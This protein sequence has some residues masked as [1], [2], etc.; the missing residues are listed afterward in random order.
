[1]IPEALFPSF[2]QTLLRGGYNLLLGSGICLDSFNGK[3][4]N[5]RSADQLRRDLCTLTGARESTSLSRVYPLLNDAQRQ[6]E[7][8]EGFSQCTPGPSIKDLSRFLWRRVFTFNIDDVLENLYS[9]EETAKQSLIPL[10]FDSPFE[11]TPER[12][13]L[14]AIHLHGWVRHPESGFVFSATEY[15]RVMQNLNPWMHLLGE[16]L[17]TEPFIIAGTSLTEVDLEYYLSRRSP[18]TPRRDRGPSLLIE[19]D[20]DVVTKS[21]CERHQLLLIQATFGQFLDWL[22]QTFPSPPSVADLLVPDISTLFSEGL[23]NLQLVRFFSD[24]ELVTAGDEDLSPRPSPFLYGREPDWNDLHQHVDIE[25][26]DNTSLLTLVE[27]QFAVQEEPPANLIVALDDAGTGKTTT[28]KRV[29]HSVA[30]AGKPVLTVRTLSRIDTTNAA[31]CLAHAKNPLLLVVDG[32]ADHAEQLAGLLTFTQASTPI[33]VLACERMYRKEY[34]DIVFGAGQYQYFEMS[35]LIRP[36]LIQL[37][38][39]YRQYGLIG[40]PRAL[41]NPNDFAMKL[42]SDPVAVAVCRILNDFRPLEAIVDSLWQAAAPEDRFAYLSVALAQHCYPSG[43]R[44]SILQTIQGP[45][46]PIA[47]LFERS[48]P[49]RIAQRPGEDDFVVAINGVVAERVLQRV[50]RREP[51]VLQKAFSGLAFALAPHV[52]RTAIKLRSPEARLARRLF[53]ADKIVRPMLGTAAEPF[54]LEIQ[55]KWEWNSRY[56]EQR[57]LLIADADLET[58]LR[59]ARHA[60]SIEEHPFP[61]TTLGK[62]LLRE[63]EITAQ[64]RDRLFDQAYERLVKAIELETW[65]SRITV[66]PFVTLFNGAALYMELGGTLKSHQRTKLTNYSAEAGYRFRRDPNVAAVVHRFEEALN[67]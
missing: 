48:A 35:P 61:L 63:M 19:P 27:K 15:V 44:Y 13:E 21:D 59:Y 41:R 20:P 53:D 18:A 14:Y 12:N 7:L 64:D 36:E 25:R 58:A 31:K 67:G 56:W 33:V 22:I 43:V 4:L 9:S 50:S 11:P 45:H 1:M 28:I 2:R 37:V 8:V 39:R 24:F 46:T 55:E 42:R 51:L 57:A 30:S 10:N 65:H 17:A 29:A 66:H 52:N 3:G 38:E 6:S 60:V 40:D 16:I 23:T 54:Y 34:L 49:L 47:P 32:L 62:L 5:L 26:R